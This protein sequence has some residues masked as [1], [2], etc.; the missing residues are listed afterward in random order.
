MSELE[1][2]LRSKILASVAVLEKQL[3]GE[4]PSYID[5]LLAKK[6]VEPGFREFIRLNTDP[7]ILANKLKSIRHN[8]E[9]GR[10][11]EADKALDR[12][13]QRRQHIQG[14]LLKF[15]LVEYANKRGRIRSV[16][17]DENLDAIDAEMAAGKKKLTAA[18]S[19]VEARGLAMDGQDPRNVANGLVKAHNDREQARKKAGA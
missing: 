14:L 9:T 12:F 19:V 11:I 3:Q 1:D 15:G 2:Y 16:S 5:R 17:T 6:N 13:E 8:A 10:L 18:L 7:A 4:Q